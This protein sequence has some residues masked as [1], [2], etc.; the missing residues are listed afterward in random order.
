MNAILALCMVSLFAWWVWSLKQELAH[1][2]GQATAGTG[3]APAPAPAPT[4]EY[5]APIHAAR[6]QERP[7]YT[8]S[9]KRRN[10]GGVAV[11]T[12]S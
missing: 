10:A 2:Q 7:I 9:P 3:F 4:P 8:E 12:I 11:W 6:P 1:Y 5:T